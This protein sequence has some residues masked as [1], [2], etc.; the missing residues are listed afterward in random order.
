MQELT[1]CT[2]LQPK[3][4][5]VIVYKVPEVYFPAL[6]DP[7]EGD[8]QYATLPGHPELVDYIKVDPVYWNQLLKYIVE[9]EEAVEALYCY[10]EQPP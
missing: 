2:T 3:A 6:P 8:I 7:A 1:S 10:D 5:V 9:T 4:E